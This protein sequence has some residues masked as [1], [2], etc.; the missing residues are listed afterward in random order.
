MRAARDAGADTAIVTANT[1]RR[2]RSTGHSGSKRSAA[3][4]LVR[5]HALRISLSTMADI[6]TMDKI[7]CAS[8]GGAASSSRRP[9]FYGGLGGSSYD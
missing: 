4:H 9:R 8:A 7:V 6:V 1:A 2:E 3:K 5:P